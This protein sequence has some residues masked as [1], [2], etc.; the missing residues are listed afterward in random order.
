MK[1]ST[2][3][4]VA[5]VAGITFLV[6]CSS[7]NTDQ[8]TKLAECLTSKG[9]TMYGT[10]RCSHCQAQKDLFGYEAFSKIKF[11][12]CDKEKN[13]CA[14]EWVQGYPT[15][16]FANGSKLEGEQTFQALAQAAWCNLDGSS[17]TTVSTGT[18]QEVSTGEVMTGDVVLT[19]GTQKVVSGATGN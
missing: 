6:G 12:D 16:K 18:I 7:T 9:T 1:I 13:I 8:N 14:V 17:S 4:V 11:V 3:S 10:N 19:T 2:L 5:M 15:W